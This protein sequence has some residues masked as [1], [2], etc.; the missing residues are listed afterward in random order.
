MM[1]LSI[2]TINYNNAEGLRKTLASVASQTYAEIEHIIVDG[3]STDDSVEILRAYPHPLPKGKGE[4][5]GDKYPTQNPAHKVLWISE[6]DKGIYN[7][8]N[9]GLEIALGRRVVTN[10]HTS[11]SIANSQW[12]IAQTDY[13][14]ILN[15]GDI[16][17]AP[18]VTER[19]MAALQNTI[20]QQHQQ[21]NIN[22]PSVVEQHTT[23]ATENNT[24]SP[25][26]L[27]SDSVQASR[28]SPLAS[29]LKSMVIILA[30]GVLS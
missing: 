25:N 13:I 2:I 24:S 18:D 22:N 15:S 29:R 12:P 7:A 8:M 28:L 6:K 30:N 4:V 26:C 9:N 10:N 23:T 19:M 16:L 14:Q 27:T 1:K 3:G 5:S 21:H 11:L 17:A 20:K